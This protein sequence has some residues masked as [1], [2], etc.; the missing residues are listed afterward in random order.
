MSQRHRRKSVREA[1]LLSNTST[2]SSNLDIAYEVLP[3]LEEKWARALKRFRQSRSSSRKASIVQMVPSCERSFA[4]VDPSRR[5]ASGSSGEHTLWSY[6]VRVTLRPATPAVLTVGAFFVLDKQGGRPILL[7]PQALLEAAQPGDGTVVIEGEKELSNAFGAQLIGFCFQPPASPDGGRWRR[8]RNG[9]AAGELRA[10]HTELQESVLARVHRMHVT[11]ALLS[12]LELKPLESNMP[13]APAEFLQLSWSQL[14][15]RGLSRSP[16]ASAAAAAADAVRELLP[17]DALL[18]EVGGKSTIG[19][20]AHECLRDLERALAAGQPLLISPII[21][22][23]GLIST[24]V[25][26]AHSVHVQGFPAPCTP[27][28]RKRRTAAQQNTP[29]DRRDDVFAKLPVHPLQQ[30]PMRLY[31]HSEKTKLGAPVGGE[32]GMAAP[33]ESGTAQLHTVLNK[34]AAKAERESADGE[35]AGVAAEQRAETSELERVLRHTI[36]TQLQGKQEKEELH[37]LKKSGRSNVLDQGHATD[38]QRG[39]YKTPLQ[40][41]ST[42]NPARFG[43]DVTALPLFVSFRKDLRKRHARV[44]QVAQIMQDVHVAERRQQPFDYSPFLQTNA[45]AAPRPQRMRRSR[46]GVSRDGE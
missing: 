6:A 33:K 19:I 46:D 41:F 16:A 11:S 31:I 5:I 42:S 22:L 28:G 1:A 25:G 40:H 27:T 18:L 14:Q 21:A 44:L 15:R 17:N 34:R 4:V 45:T 2:I 26:M 43:G 36:G 29:Q 35:N 30:Q 9:H 8:G 10:C 37:I 38:G 23:Q 20:S 12:G 32:R 3:F 39:I 13:D 7:R 24:A